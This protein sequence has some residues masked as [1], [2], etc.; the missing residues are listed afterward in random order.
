MVVK[1]Q[2]LVCLEWASRKSEWE[3]LTIL[4]TAVATAF[5]ANLA[6]KDYYRIYFDHSDQEDVSCKGLTQHHLPEAI[7]FETAATQDFVNNNVFEDA[8][9]T[10]SSAARDLIVL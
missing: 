3:N 6:A 7:T 1:C 10:C 5:A 8:K 9:T 4:R 2:D